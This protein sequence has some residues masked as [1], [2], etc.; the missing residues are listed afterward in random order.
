ME[1]A[2]V[3]WPAQSSERP[4]GAEE[5]RAHTALTAVLIAASTMT[6]TKAQRQLANSSEPKWKRA[7]QPPS[8]GETKPPEERAAA[9]IEMARDR[10]RAVCVP[11]AT[12]ARLVGKIAA[13]PSPERI[14]PVH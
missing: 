6:A 1:T 12:M 8:T 2:M 13:A 5:S 9:Q 7:S 3:I 11:A 10:S 14:W 4:A